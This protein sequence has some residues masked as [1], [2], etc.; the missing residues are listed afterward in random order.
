MKP[1]KR[2]QNLVHNVSEYGGFL[3]YCDT[4]VVRDNAG[5]EGCS[6]RLLKQQLESG[7]LNIYRRTSQQVCLSVCLQK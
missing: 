2:L 1:V 3:C 4:D 5:A 7:K 6:T